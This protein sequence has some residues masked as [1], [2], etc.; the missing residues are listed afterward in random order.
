[1]KEIYTTKT[2]VKIGLAYERPLRFTVG[3]DMERLQT[4]LLSQRRKIMPNMSTQHLVDIVCWILAVV[5][6]VGMFAI[7]SHVFA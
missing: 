4:A 5:A 3:Q 7:G 6:L 1:M 2:G